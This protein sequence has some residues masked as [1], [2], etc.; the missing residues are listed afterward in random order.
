MPFG[1]IRAAGGKLANWASGPGYGARAGRAVGGFLANH[2]VASFYGASM[3]V[4]GG[5]GM[6]SDSDSVI[7]NSLQWGAMAGIG[8]YGAAGF[9]GARSAYQAMGAGAGWKE[10][11]EAMARGSWNRIRAAGKLDYLRGA[12]LARRAKSYY[13]ARTAASA[14][15][16]P[17]PSTLNSGTSATAQNVG[18]DALGGLFRQPQNLAHGLSVKR[19]RSGL[20]GGAPL[21]VGR[22]SRDNVVK[23]ST[24]SRRKNNPGLSDWVR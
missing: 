3:G 23:Y 17:V 10:S 4:G 2:P 9:R 12:A 21:R 18:G 11:G 5:I 6:M 14:P 15:V 1:A 7:G 24:L 19:L 8:R 13:G 16:N 22:G 20:S